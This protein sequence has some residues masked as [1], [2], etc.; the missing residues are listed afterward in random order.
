[1]INYA[2]GKHS[3]NRRKVPTWLSGALIVGGAGLLFWLEKRHPLR[4]RV[5]SRVTRN[6][7]NFTVAAIAAVSL[8]FVET[9]IIRSL[10][11]FVESRRCGLLKRLYLPLWLEVT[12]ALVLMDYTLY[13]WHVLMHRVP[14]LWRF[15]IVHHADLDLDAST[16]LRF[17]AGELIIGTGWRACQVVLIGV[18]PLSISVWQTFLFLSVLFH[19]SNLRLP[20]EVERKLNSVIVT[21]RMHGIHHSIIARD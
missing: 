8:Q 20:I 9:P 16:A 4:R 5:E 15:H 7:R 10:T 2:Q 13:L 3:V 1:M 11:T 14:I 18:S 6:A 17:H 21:P 19:H 12:L